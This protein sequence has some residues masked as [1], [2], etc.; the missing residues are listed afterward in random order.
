MLQ[1]P[2]LFLSCNIPTAEAATAR[3]PTTTKG[4]A[5]TQPC[6][7]YIRWTDEIL[8]PLQDFCQRF[9]FS[10]PL[11]GLAVGRGVRVPVSQHLMNSS[12]LLSLSPRTAG[13]QY[14]GVVVV[15]AAAAL[16]HPGRLVAAAAAVRCERVSSHEITIG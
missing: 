6:P 16:V 15:V 11:D 4:A 3:S 1:Q 9:P 5:T 7:S 2:L 13:P 8:P 14:S 10:C 12:Y